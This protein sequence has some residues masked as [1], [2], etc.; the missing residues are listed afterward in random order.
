MGIASANPHETSL[1]HLGVTKGFKVLVVSTK[2][3]CDSYDSEL[4]S[5]VRFSLVLLKNE[6][7]ICV[8]VFVRR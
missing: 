8:G 1:I 5:Y 4:G 2:Y 7:K 6:Q 3:N